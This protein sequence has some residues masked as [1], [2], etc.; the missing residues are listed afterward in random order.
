ML[1]CA[2]TLQKEASWKME[3]TAVF[4][5]SAT[6]KNQLATM[7][8]YVAPAPWTRPPVPA[9]P[10]LHQPPDPCALSGRQL[11][12]NGRPGA[13][14]LVVRERLSDWTIKQI[15]SV[16]QGALLGM[17]RADRGA[18]GE[19]EKTKWTPR[20]PRNPNDFNASVMEQLSWRVSDMLRP[21][22]HK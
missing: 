12:S 15:P 5:I 13:H 10:R 8:V 7:C 2:V 21:L 1:S 22:W 16:Q 17:K 11:D 4:V 18:G 20:R 3:L 9:P 14:T 19:R 6:K